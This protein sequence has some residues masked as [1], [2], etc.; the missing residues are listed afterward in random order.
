MAKAMSRKE[1]FEKAKLE[2]Q[3]EKEQGA[4]YNYTGEGGSESVVYTA[5]TPETG[6]VVRMY[7]NPLVMR[8]KPTDPKFVF[9][10]MILGDNG[11]KFRCIFPTKEENSDW[12][13]WR[14]YDL[15]AS[16]TMKGDFNTPERARVYTYKNSHYE[17]WKRVV[18]NNNEENQY[19]AGW[20]PTGF[21]LM[22]V[23]DRHDPDFHKEKKHSKVLSKKAAEM[24]N[25]D[26]WFEP[27]VP[28]SA[29]NAIWDNVVEFYG[30]WEDYD[31]SVKKLRDQPWY[32]AYHAVQEAVKLSPAEKNVVVDGPMTA[33]EEAYELYDFDKLFPVTSYTKIQA[34]LGKFIRKV[35]ADF[36]RNFSEELEKLVKEEQAEWKKN[37]QEDKVAKESSGSDEED[38]TSE[39]QEAQKPKEQID[40]AKVRTR[41][42]KREVTQEEIDWNALADGSY[43]DTKYL[44]VP[45]MTEEEK[46]MVLSIKA[47]GQF[48]YVKEYKGEPI[49]LLKSIDSDFLSPSIFHVDPL[50]GDVFDEEEEE[51]IF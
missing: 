28:I 12:L 51:P 45:K 17:C 46:S 16:F 6:R 30:P 19:E 14:I 23:I 39:P 4:S 10:S 37:N 21:V 38:T 32:M 48:E 15:V 34:K 35:D 9:I 25:G 22:N 26:F 13:L 11:K 50:S 44:G 24:G 18:K 47:N 29:Y 49:E 8:E 40:P 33:E 43:N 31:V 36:D 2:R 5:L 27:G 20:R 1:I 42:P 7:G 3:R 41:A